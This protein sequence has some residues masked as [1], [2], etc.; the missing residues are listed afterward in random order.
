[1]KTHFFKDLYCSWF[2]DRGIRLLPDRKIEN[3]APRPLWSPSLM[4]GLKVILDAPPTAAVGLC[5]YVRQPDGKACIE[6][7][8]LNSA[9]E[10]GKQFR[11][12]PLGGTRPYRA[13]SWSAWT[14]VVSFSS[15]Q[16][17]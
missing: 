8:M 7:L 3:L 16:K 5:S 17:F 6:D 13:I 15:T 4:N 14:S 2:S 10:G 11:V 9:I 12:R 1:M